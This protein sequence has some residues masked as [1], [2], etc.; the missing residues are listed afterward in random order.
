MKRTISILL[1]SI[2]AILFSFQSFAQTKIDKLVGHVF[3]CVRQQ[4]QNRIS[5]RERHLAGMVGD[6]QIRAY[7]ESWIADLDGK[8]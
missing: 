3:D 8:R 4:T 5:D 7:L 1:F 2:C 6:A